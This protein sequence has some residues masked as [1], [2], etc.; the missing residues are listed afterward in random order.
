MRAGSPS[1]AHDSTRPLRY[2]HPRNDGFRGDTALA[3]HKT[4]ISLLRFKEGPLLRQNPGPEVREGDLS[5]GQHR[6]HRSFNRGL[7]PL[8]HF[9]KKLCVTTIRICLLGSRAC[10][11]E[12]AG[13]TLLQACNISN[14]IDIVT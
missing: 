5:A 3:A 9:G 12:V 6:D 1:V 7:N 8:G 11:D 14:L 4:G 2:R 13:V 10:L